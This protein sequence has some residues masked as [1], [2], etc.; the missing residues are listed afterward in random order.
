MTKPE[1]STGQRSNGRLIYLGGNGLFE[2][3]AYDPSDLSTMLLRQGP[4][5]AA[6]WL[7]RDQG[8]S[9]RAVLGVAYQSESYMNAVTGYRTRAPLHRFLAGTDLSLDDSFGDTGLTGTTG[10]SDN[11]CAC[12]W[13]MDT[14]KTTPDGGPPPGNLVVLA[15]SLNVDYASQMTAWDT[16]SGGFV[17]SVGS[18][19]FGGSLVTDQT[20]TRIL[21]NVLDDCAGSAFRA[22]WQEVILYWLIEGILGISPQGKAVPVPLD[23][24]EKDILI[25]LAVSTLGRASSS[26]QT[27]NALNRAGLKIVSE[28]AQKALQEIGEG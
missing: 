23:G 22:P 28:A 24:P 9:E 12:G 19:C 5:P 15:E 11:G 7:F 21:R 8:R 25:G 1:N 10:S 27:Q 17:F 3:V 18:L 16:P 26:P 4:D 14:S 13:E 20:L 6:R 2:R